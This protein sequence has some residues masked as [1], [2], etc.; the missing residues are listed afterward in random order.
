LSI[1]K[2]T[3]VYQVRQVRAVILLFGIEPFVLSPDEIAWLS[4]DRIR[5]PIFTFAMAPIG[6]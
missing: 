6:L 4:E 1:A 2:H 5:R 3:K